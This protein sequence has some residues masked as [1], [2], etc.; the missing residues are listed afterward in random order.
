M[1]I[2]LRSL[3]LF[4]E[5]SIR[6]SSTLLAPFPRRTCN[7]RLRRPCSAGKEYNGASPER[8]TPGGARSPKLTANDGRP[9][10]T[11]ES[12]QYSVFH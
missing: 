2:D 9:C 5:L 11:V 8:H 6:G 1:A 3:V 12:V 7:T 4:P 10:L